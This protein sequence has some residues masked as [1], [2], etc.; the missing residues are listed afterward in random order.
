[1]ACWHGFE[2]ILLEPNKYSVR[3][4]K[5]R[6]E[7]NGLTVE[8]VNAA[9]SCLPIRSETVDVVDFYWTRHNIPDEYKLLALREVYRILKP[10]GI[11]VSASFGYWEESGMPSKDTFC[12]QRG[13]DFVNIHLSAGFNPSLR[14]IRNLTRCIRT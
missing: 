9:A 10:N 12:C 8:V 2:C 3:F 7:K 6:A 5:R 4:A 1:M 11:L 14:F 13:E